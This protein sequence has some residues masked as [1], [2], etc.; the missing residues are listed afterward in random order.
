MN[1]LD[2]WPQFSSRAYEE[3]AELRS[4]EAFL[5]FLDESEQRFAN[6][7]LANDWLQI[8]EFYT[9]DL[10]RL[11]DHTTTQLHMRGMPGFWSKLHAIDC[12]LHTRTSLAPVRAIGSV[13]FFRGRTLNPAERTVYLSYRRRTDEGLACGELFNPEIGRQRAALVRNNAKFWRSLNALTDI[14][15]MNVYSGSDRSVP[16]NVFPWPSEPN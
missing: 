9:T 3:N 4:K 7:T 8:V 12:V 2:G 11:A 15:D 13:F 1:R 10:Q 14:V 5:A 16:A 6:R